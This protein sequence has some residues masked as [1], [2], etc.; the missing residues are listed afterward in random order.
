[1]DFSHDRLFS[2]RRTGGIG[3]V[4]LVHILLA[5]ALIYGLGSLNL[6]PVTEVP[7]K[8]TMKEPP[9]VQRDEPVPATTE[10]KPVRVRID[11]PAAPSIPGGGEARLVVSDAPAEG[12]SASSALKGDS[13]AIGSAA[14]SKPAVHVNSPVMYDFDA[15]R[16]S[17]PPYA[18][19]RG[20]EGTVQLRL[21]VDANDQLASIS[22][23]KS[24]MHPALDHAAVAGL[25]RCKFKAATHDGVPVSSTIV[26]D[27][28]WSINY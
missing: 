27:Y 23:L 20:E 28:M 15:C 12:K 19:N 26:I 5:A 16:P 17:Y 11:L 7:A 25:G 13:D 24:S 9:V 22:V 3:L 6:H 2:A 14:A 8:L 18:L 1:M 10:R 4:A 21:V